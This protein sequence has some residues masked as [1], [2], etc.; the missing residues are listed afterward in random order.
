MM[1]FSILRVWGLGIFSWLLLG[2][3]VYCGWRA[4]DQ[5]RRDSSILVV[6]ETADDPTTDARDEAS[7]IVERQPAE[8]RIS[9]EAWWWMA[10]VLGL[11]GLSFGG[12]WPVH[13]LLG[14]QSGPEPEQLQPT[15]QLFIDRPD[16]S[17]LYVQI[18]GN[19]SAP[20]LLLTHGWSLN[21]STWDYIKRRLAERFRLVM[22][23]LPGLGRS[24]GAS[25]G[26]CSIEKLAHDLD[27]VIDS[28]ANATPLVLVSHSIGSF[29]TQTLCRLRPK[30]FGS[31]VQGFV[32]LHPTYVNPLRTCFLSP[33]ATALEWPLITPLNYLTIALAPLAWLS[34]WQSYYNGSLHICT[35]LSTFSGQQTWNQLDHAARLA[36]EAWPGVLAR[37]NLAMQRFDEER[38]LPHIAVPTLL[39]AGEHDRMTLPAA[40]DH[41]ANLLPNDRPFRVSSGHLGYWEQ[42]DEV[43][44]VIEEFVAHI[45]QAADTPG[46][47]RPGERNVMAAASKSSAARHT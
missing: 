26:E 15:Q 12:H 13:W 36:A 41:M 44:E 10:G 25:N 35:R 30:Q 37:G 45:V 19:N 23:D 6:R 9:T 2:A 39:I 43:A 16:G 5:I 7:R 38:T 14:N 8:L 33:L 42:P 31:K 17:R 18:Y 29:A 20:T 28:T 21:V 4:Y 24:R 32:L 46:E 47:A 34:N 27:S 3:A 1:P 11:L 40:A 22:W